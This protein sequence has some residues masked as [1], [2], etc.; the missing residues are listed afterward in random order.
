MKKYIL[1]ILILYL[2]V[3]VNAQTSLEPGAKQE[4]FKLWEVDIKEIFPKEPI[5][6]Y[7]SPLIMDTELV[8]G[9]ESG[10]VKTLDV[11][12]KKV[13]RVIKLPM[14]IE[15][16]QQF[17][18]SESTKFAVFFG[19]HLKSF[20]YY[21]CSVDLEQKQMK[22]VVAHDKEFLSLGE[23][24]IFELNNNFVVFNPS[25][26][27]GVYTQKER[28]YDINKKIFTQDTK[29][30]IFQ[31]SKG[32]LVE[33]GLPKFGAS[34]IMSPRS[35]RKDIL[36]FT[37][38]ISLKPD[39]IADNLTGTTLYYHSTSGMIGLMD[40]EEKKVI[41]E[42]KYFKEGMSI[43]G[44]YRIKEKLFYLVS[45]PPEK[46]KSNKGKL[47]CINKDTGQSI[48]VSDDLPFNNFGIVNFDRYILSVNDA[49]ELLFLSV[50]DGS[51]RSFV[52]VGQGMSRPIVVQDDLYVMTNT[53]IYRFFSNR[54]GFKARLLWKKFLNSIT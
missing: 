5:S 47:I 13:R 50:E 20:K 11:D 3:F 1:A 46:G 54:I 10:V 49:G 41:W 23:F 52:E 12:T 18:F 6:K 44:P 17:D 4:I 16:S 34:L 27:R 33:I 43:Q 14:G 29:R 25:V 39:Q 40:V 30:Y 24:A 37:E 45:Y 38:I 51:L 42:R 53:K 28:K 32:K 19:P 31:T 48:W 35:N 22:G 9:S 2:S 8:F 21:Y 26:G 15:R 7:Y 36:E